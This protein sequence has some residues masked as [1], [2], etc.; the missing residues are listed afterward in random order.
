M[1]PYIVPFVL[2]LLGIAALA[3][4]PELFPWGYPVVGIVVGLTAWRLLR[5]RNLIVPHASIWPGILVGIL[6]IAVWIGLSELRL[7]Q[8][9][10]PYLPSWLRPEQRAGYNPG[11][12]LP[13]PWSYGGFLAARLL[14][15]VI[16]VPLVEELFWRGFL[17][18]WLKSPNWEQVPLGDFSKGSFWGVVVLFGLAHPEWLA[19]ASYSAM[20]NGLLMWKRDLWNCIVAHAVSNM[21]LAVYILKTEAWWLW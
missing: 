8:Q 11:E 3:V 1:I 12:L 20:L 2:Y 14:G 13:N 4:E 19:A 6:G 5:G 10:A 15:L 9:L 17:S 7:E 16:L 21:L 18:R